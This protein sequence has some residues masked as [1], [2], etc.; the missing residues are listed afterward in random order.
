MGLPWQLQ[1]LFKI[2]LLNEDGGFI[3][4]CLALALTSRPENSGNLDP[5]SKFVQLR[6]SPA[7]IALQVFSVG[8]IVSCVHVIR[9]IAISS[10]TGDGW[11]E[12]WL[13]NSHI[14]QATWNDVYDTEREICIFRTGRRNAWRDIRNDTHC[15]A[16]L[17]NL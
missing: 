7:V 12:R 15:L 13:V 9:E 10:T 6:K 14:D 3:E 17:Y 16:H 1:P 11:N 4:Y 2:K 5:V 8:N